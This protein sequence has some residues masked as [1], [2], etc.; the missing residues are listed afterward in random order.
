MNPY[1]PE[2]VRFGDNDRLSA[3]IA[4]RIKASMLIILTNVDGFYI[5]NSKGK[6]ALVKEIRKID[7]DLLK[8]ASGPDRFGRGG[9]ITKL[10]AAKIA[11]RSG[12]L[13][14]I[15]NGA[16]KDAISEALNGR[17]SGTLVFPNRN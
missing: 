5:K 9:M 2:R 7:R 15:T 6:Q 10:E 17:P 3:L 11:A 4:S 12:V 16:N 8:Y 13:T 1:L 14:V